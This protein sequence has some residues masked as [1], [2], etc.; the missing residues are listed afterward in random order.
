MTR[1]GGWTN[2]LPVFTLPGLAVKRASGEMITPYYL[3][4]EDLLE[5]AKKLEA[6]GELKEKDRSGRLA[7]RNLP[8][9]LC[10]AAGIKLED[11][12]TSMFQQALSLLRWRKIGPLTGGDAGIVPPRREIDWLRRNYR[13]KEGLRGEHSQVLVLEEQQ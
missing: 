11:D 10:S 3:A 13:H 9:V 7:V 5:D 12:K 1:D 4:Y 6:Q 8:D 2:R